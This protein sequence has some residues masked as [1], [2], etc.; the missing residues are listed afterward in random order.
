MLQ[1][2]PDAEVL[3]PAAVRDEIVRAGWRRLDMSHRHLL[4]VWNPS[5]ASNAME[6]HLAVLL[7]SAARWNARETEI[8]PHV[9]WGK[10]RS[11]NRRQELK[12]LPQ[13]LDIAS[14]L[15]TDDT[16]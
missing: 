13:I 8:D 14:E 12:H 2:G 4:D 5:Y 9:W 10:V 11:R 7:E 16:A 6:A 15:S 1:Y 3:E